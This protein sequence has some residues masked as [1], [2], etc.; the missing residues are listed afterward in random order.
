MNSTVLP[1][2]SRLAPPWTPPLDAQALHQLLEKVQQWEP[3]DADAL[4]D[5][6][7]EVLD[8]V[9]PPAD[10]LEELAGRL[11]RHLAQLI[12]IGAGTSGDKG[13][14]QADRLVRRARQLRNAV[15]PGEYGQTVGHLRRTAWTVNELTEH[16]VTLGC[17]KAVAA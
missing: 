12:H 14:E 4:L 15:L 10:E 5:D 2:E 16:L 8:D 11:G 9:A 6:V 1:S 3:F 13:D 7:G 17:L